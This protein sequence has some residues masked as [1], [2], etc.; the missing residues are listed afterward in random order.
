MA[1]L[2]PQVQIHIIEIA[3]GYATSTNTDTGVYAHKNNLQVFDEAYKA[4]IKTVESK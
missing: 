2:D 3:W 4:L 1:E